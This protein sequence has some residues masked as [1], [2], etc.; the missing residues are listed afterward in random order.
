MT[1]PTRCS[2]PFVNT[3]PI[4]TDDEGNPLPDY[5]SSQQRINGAIRKIL[6]A[7]EKS[8]YVGYTA[9]PFANIFIYPQGRYRQP[10]RRPVPSQLH[11]QSASAIELCRPRAGLRNRSD[12]AEGRRASGQNGGPPTTTRSVEDHQAWLPDKHKKEHVPGCSPGFARRRRSSASSLASAARAARGQENEHNSML[13]HVDPLHRRS[14]KKKGGRSCFRGADQPS[15]TAAIWRWKHQ[16]S[17]HSLRIEA[18]LGNR[19]CTR[20]QGYKGQRAGR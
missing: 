13:I 14:Q 20:N 5:R 19:L 9:T 2:T 4:P 10:R 18:A 7:F 15:A 1:R 12:A 11:H 6:T 17:A 3:N 16:I 8:A